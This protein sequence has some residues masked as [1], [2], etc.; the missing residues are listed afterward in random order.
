MHIHFRVF[1][2]SLGMLISV[3]LGDPANIWVEDNHFNS[4]SLYSHQQ[5]APN[6]PDYHDLPPEVQESATLTS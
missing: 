2:I 6:P 3:V 4:C 5:M 1:V